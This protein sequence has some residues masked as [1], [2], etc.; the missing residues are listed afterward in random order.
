MFLE[1]I[2]SDYEEG[3][4]TVVCIPQVSR[5]LTQNLEK[6]ENQEAISMLTAWDIKVFI[7]GRLRRFLK[8]LK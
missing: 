4:D 1:V 7:F 5:K 2:L 3:S 6:S 8:L